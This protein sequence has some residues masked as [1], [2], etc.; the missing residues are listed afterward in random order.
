MRKFAISLLLVLVIG[1]IL[2]FAW[3]RSPLHQVR[4][5]TTAIEI[6][7]PPE[8]VWQV[9]TDFPSYPDWNPF[10]VDARGEARVGQRLKIT[11]K[12]GDGSTVF[13]PTVLTANPGHELRW[14]GHYVVPGIFDGEHR[15][16]LEP[17][18]PNN[19]VL[20][21]SESFDGLLVVPLWEKIG[22]PTSKGFRQMNQALKERAEA[23]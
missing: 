23:H 20:T 16:M 13:R 3:W 22:A 21:Q 11:I 15:F 14:V 9:L 7:A 6:Y 2:L 12:S 4:T 1:G 10:I 18:G 19:T 8:R 17:D 5:I